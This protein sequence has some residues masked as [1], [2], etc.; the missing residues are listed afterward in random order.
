MLRLDFPLSCQCSFFIVLLLLL[1][2]LK[3]NGISDACCGL[4]LSLLYLDESDCRFIMGMERF[5]HPELGFLFGHH[6]VTDGT[7]SLCAYLVAS[8]HGISSCGCSSFPKY[9]C[10]YFLSLLIF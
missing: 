3:G 8:W 4:D 7:W 1:L 6:D 10:K 2:L 5:S 9:T